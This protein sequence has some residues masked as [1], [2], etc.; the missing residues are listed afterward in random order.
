MPTTKIFTV[1]EVRNILDDLHKKGLRY[2]VTN[3]DQVN[4][5]NQ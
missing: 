1:F 2:M 5:S 4:E 3:Q